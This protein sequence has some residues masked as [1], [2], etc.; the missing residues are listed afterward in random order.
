MK[1]QN[2]K[3]YKLEIKKQ[4]MNARNVLKHSLLVLGIIVLIFFIY[5]IHPKEIYNILFA[6]TSPLPLLILTLCLTFL[7]VLFKAHRWR[8]LIHKIT[9]IK[10]SLWFSTQSVFAGVAAGSF[11]PG[12]IELARPLIYKTEHGIPITKSLSALIIERALDLL[13][14]LFFLLIGLL[15]IPSQNIISLNVVIIFISIICTCIILS[16]AFPKPLSAFFQK[17]ICFFPLPLRLKTKITESIAHAIHSFIIFRTHGT[18]INIAILSLITNALEIARFYFIAQAFG[19]PATITILAITFSAGILLGVLSAIP[20]GIG[21]TE[22]S[23][24]TIIVAL[25]P[26]TLPAIAK[27]AILLDRAI[28]YYIVILIGIYFL[29]HLGYFSKQRPL[30]KEP[31]SPEPDQSPSQKS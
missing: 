3:T 21:I 1:P 16:I 15:F 7:S 2:P 5:T 13:C 23:S 28:S 29:I 4:I 18:I 11:L 24:S 8:I 27:S 31:F 30:P 9:D 6:L 12:R 25:L 14:F 10:T 20:G 22:F 19:I 26:A 17:I